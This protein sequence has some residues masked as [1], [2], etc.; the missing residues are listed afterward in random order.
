M[1]ARARDPALFA[2]VTL[3]SLG[4]DVEKIALVRGEEQTP[5]QLAQHYGQVEAFDSLQECLA[6]SYLIIMLQARLRG[7][8]CRR[9]EKR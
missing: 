9:R 1:C 3:H 6:S 7:K 5:L 4:A 8:L 2:L